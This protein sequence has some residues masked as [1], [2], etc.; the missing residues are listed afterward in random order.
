MKK[1]VLISFGDRIRSLREGE[2]WSQEE[3]AEHTGFHRTYIGMVER[4]ERNPSLKNI[5]KFADAFGMELSQLMK[6]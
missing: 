2:D 5:K 3:L 4:G 6:F 1:D